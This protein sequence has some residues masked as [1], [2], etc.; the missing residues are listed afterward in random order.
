MLKHRK[1][2]C[3]ARKFT[4]ISKASISVNSCG[5]KVF[6]IPI[7]KPYIGD[8]EK[9]AVLEVLDSG[10]LAQGPRVALLEEKFAAACGVKHAI[11][12]SNGTTALY[13]A[14]LAHG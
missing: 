4:R 13:L 3:A 10:M 1:L 11:A 9:Q 5:K 14:L 12:T 6:M 7:S 2:S 8:A